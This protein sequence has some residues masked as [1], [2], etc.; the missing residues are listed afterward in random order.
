M[1]SAWRLLSLPADLGAFF[2]ADY[3]KKELGKQT[4]KVVNVILS[5]KGGVS[6]GTVAS[7]KRHTEI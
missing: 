6:G 1:Y 5:G 3:I 4:A 7:G 2:V